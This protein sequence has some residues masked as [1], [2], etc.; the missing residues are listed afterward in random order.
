[1][2]RMQ[3]GRKHKALWSM[4]KRLGA[5]ILYAAMFQ[6]GVMA[7]FDHIIASRCTG[8]FY[9]PKRV[10]ALIH[11][12]NDTMKEYEE[13]GRYEDVA[14]L[15]GRLDALVFLVS[16]DAQRRHFPNYFA[17]GVDEAIVTK[18]AFLRIAKKTSKLH[19]KAFK[20]AVKILDKHKGEGLAIH[21]VPY[22][23]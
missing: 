15:Q 8:T 23:Y 12:T 21:H 13:L 17:F 11:R 20:R 6:D 4:S 2:K 10:H 14:Y 1:M 16:N 19:P 5:P 7:T 3:V 22:L 18:G 9:D